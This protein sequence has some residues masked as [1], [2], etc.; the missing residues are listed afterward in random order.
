MKYKRNHFL[1][2]ILITSMLLINCSCNNKKE[3]KTPDQLAKELQTKVVECFINDDKEEL[4]KLFSN[5]TIEK[6]NNIDQ[7][8]NEAFDFINGNIISYDEPISRTIGN[9]D[10]KSYGASTDNIITDKGS[11]F[12]IGFTGWLT[13]ANNSNMI[14]ITY[15]QICDLGVTYDA[16]NNVEYKGIKYIGYVDD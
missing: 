15:I 5:Y 4:K 7:E 11:S 16:N 13:N 8:I 2:I 1:F 14:G 6:T 10:N 3:N 9:S 12:K